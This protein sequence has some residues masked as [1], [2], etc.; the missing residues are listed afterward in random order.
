ML[1]DGLRNSMNRYEKSLKATQGVAKKLENQL[2]IMGQALTSTNSAQ[3]G[4]SSLT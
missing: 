1:S 3:T 4:E 2:P